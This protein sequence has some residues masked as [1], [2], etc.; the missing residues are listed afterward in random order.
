MF[1]ILFATVAQSASVGNLNVNLSI[2]PN[3]STLQS[4]KS[5]MYTVT[6]KATGVFTQY[7]NASL[8][9]QLPLHPYTAFTQNVNDIPL[10]STIP[11]YN[12]A[13]G[14]LTYSFGT[15]NAGQVLETVLKV[16][17]LNGVSPNGADLTATANFTADELPLLTD[18]ASIQIE[19]QGGISIT[20]RYV[21]VDPT[22]NSNTCRFR[23]QERCGKSNWRSPRPQPARCI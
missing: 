14:T 6:L 10:G 21:Q 1:L 7:H 9:I 18:T 12:P 5:A 20:K 13:D 3:Q 16:D 11:V 22:Q 17:T 2:E 15:L 8:V 23:V 4:G 19:A